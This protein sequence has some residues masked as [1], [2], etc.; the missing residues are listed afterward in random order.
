[1]ERYEKLD[2]VKVHHNNNSKGKSG[3]S[4]SKKQ[5]I[6]TVLTDLESSLDTHLEPDR[7]TEPMSSDHEL[8]TLPPSQPSTVTEKR[9]DAKTRRM[10]AE[11]EPPP[12]S[13]R[14]QQVPPFVPSHMEETFENP[15]TPIPISYHEE[16]E[17][18]TE[19]RP[20]L[21]RLERPEE[22]RA[23]MMYYRSDNY[24]LDNRN[25]W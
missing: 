15:P 23:Q 8:D 14:Q 7:S 2:K 9:V 10:L 25:N 22:Q 3:T 17:I 5:E 21:N 19:K 24:V 18:S 4:K 6:I 13:R 16:S 1:M 12:V 20:L 11:K